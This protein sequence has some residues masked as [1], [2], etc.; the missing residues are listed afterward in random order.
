M[1]ALGQPFTS[2]QFL[3]DRKS[4][5]LNSSH[6]VISYAVFCLKKKKIRSVAR[7]VEASTGLSR[8]SRRILELEDAVTTCLPCASRAGHSP[9]CERGCRQPHAQTPS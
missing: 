9:P 1:V 7:F 8:T 6:L 2:C 4:T 5:R 3:L